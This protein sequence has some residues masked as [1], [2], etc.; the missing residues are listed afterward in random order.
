M[1]VSD[2]LL[3]RIAVHLALC[4]VPAFVPIRAQLGPGPLASFPSDDAKD[5][6]FLGIACAGLATLE[7][8]V[9]LALA[10]P[11]SNVTFNLNFFDGDTGA[12]DANGQFH[13]DFGT[14][15]LKFSLYADPNH[16]G[17]TEAASLI[18]EWFGNSIN[19]T[20]GPLWT[21]S[22]PSMPD[23][24]WWSVTITNAPI[25]QAASGNYFYNL[26]INADGAC[27]AGE[28]V[29]SNFKIA[30]SFPVGF[31]TS[32]FGLVGALRQNAS[33]IPILYPGSTL[34]HPVSGSFLT[35]PTTYDGTFDL[36][37]N[38]AAGTTELRLFDGDF[39][40]GT[41]LL[42][43]NPS[44]VSLDRGVDE[45]D[46]DT[47]S[48]YEGFP[49]VPVGAI[50]EGGQ[51]PGVPPD[52]NYRDIFRRGELGDPNKIG[53]V[54][55]EVRDPDGNVYFNDNPSGNS[56][57]EQFLIVSATSKFIGAADWV[58]D[59][60]TLPAGQWS[61]KIIGLDLANLNFWHADTCATRP[62]PNPSPNEDPRDLPRLAACGDEA[63]NLLGDLVWADV[64]NPGVIDPGEAGISG[65]LM[66]LV[67]P[68]DGMV[69]ATATTGD[70]SGLNWA[71]CLANRAG[72]DARGLYCFGRNVPGAYEVRVA[73]INF[74][75]GHPL[76]GTATTTGGDSRT[77]RPTLGN[78]LNLD[79]GYRAKE[80]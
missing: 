55:Y 57:W 20:H 73:E 2:Q 42:D 24:G 67:R 39:D 28:R 66:E 19:P 29:E 75:P 36:L 44:N 26:V 35:A 76:F 70:S 78:D 56:E 8:N 23:N 80:R 33:D 15:Q 13:W 64:K 43:G 62:I 17:S 50:P 25:A 5:G 21:S 6:R 46:P 22:S 58:Y 61:V 59:R 7:E 60:D 38:L 48:T 79:F 40:F 31:S 10:A 54:R 53:C 45:D 3:V 37:F 14:R 18:G 4:A 12:P 32:H 27:E 1:K 68:S 71:A 72:S 41:T 49:F 52:D 9:Q 34:T 69:I 16:V 47:P 63:T 51:E 65:V 11:A 30:T 74:A 77:H